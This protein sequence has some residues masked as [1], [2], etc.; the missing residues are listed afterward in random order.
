MAITIEDQ[1]QEFSPVYNELIFLASSN[2][3]AEAGFQYVFDIY[4]GGTLRQRH[5]IPARPDNGLGIFDARKYLESVITTNIDETDTTAFLVNSQSQ[6]IYEIKVGEKTDALGIVADLAVTGDLVA[7]NGVYDFLD[8]VDYAQADVLLLDSTKPWLTNAPTAQNIELNQ[9]LWGYSLTEFPATFRWLQI[10]RFDA[11]GAP[12]GGP[13]NIANPIAGVDDHHIR[14]G[15]GTQNLE[16]TLGAGYFTGVASYTVVATDNFFV[17]I[18]KTYTFTICT[19][20]RYPTK[21]IHFLNALGGYDAYNFTLVADDDTQIT[22]R[23]VRQLT[24]EVN[25]TN[26]WVNTKRM[27]GERITHTTKTRKLTLRSDWLTEEELAW[28]RELVESPDIMLE[29]AGDLIAI[30]PTNQTF[31]E[32]K[33]TYKQLFNLTATFDYAVRNFRQRG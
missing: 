20:C 7:W 29:D 33:H 12:I 13:S 21:R 4:T 14:F 23:K 17:P 6:R 22:R 15:V 26:D 30:N 31:R 2:N 1:P 24:G 32:E 25:G 9:F 28:L 16:T 3:T 5:L 10:Q 11:A 18:S 8:F 27:R 19:P